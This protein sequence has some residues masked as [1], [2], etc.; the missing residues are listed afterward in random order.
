MIIDLSPSMQERVNQWQRLGHK[1]DPILLNQCAYYPRGG[2]QDCTFDQPNDS[3]KWSH[4]LIDTRINPPLKQTIK[5]VKKNRKV[6][7]DV[8]FSQLPEEVRE[9][10]RRIIEGR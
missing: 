7:I 3:C 9:E 10:I 2:C 6:N 8:L 1:T 5:Q 4:I